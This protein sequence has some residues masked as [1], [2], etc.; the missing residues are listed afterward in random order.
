MREFILTGGAVTRWRPM[1]ATQC[2][3]LKVIIVVSAIAGARAAQVRNSL[4][5]E[6]AWLDCHAPSCWALYFALTVRT[7]SQAGQASTAT[8]IVMYETICKHYKKHRS[9]QWAVMCS[10]SSLWSSGAPGL[11]MLRF[12]KGIYKEADPLEI[13]RSRTQ[14]ASF[15]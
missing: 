6:K 14:N 8:G 9:E 15:S 2:R 1:F 10:P 3:D 12:L 7:N 4:L 13:W 11:R 5:C